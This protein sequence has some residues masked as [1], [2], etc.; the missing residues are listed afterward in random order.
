MVT[1]VTYTKE[2]KD[3]YVTATIDPNDVTS[4][5]D[6]YTYS[7][8]LIAG[9]IDPDA[10]D[11]TQAR[12]VTVTADNGISITE[13]ATADQDAPGADRLPAVEATYTAENTTAWS[14]G[15]IQF[16][17]T[18]DGT[19][20]TDPIAAHNNPAVVTDSIQ[21]PR[22]QPLVI[23]EEFSPSDFS[24]EALVEAVVETYPQSR[25]KSALNRFDTH[26]SKLLPPEEYLPIA[27]ALIE[28]CWPIRKY[29]SDPGMYVAKH[30]FELTSR[31]YFDRDESWYTELL[32]MYNEQ[33]NLPNTDVG[34]VHRAALFRVFT[35]ED[36]SVDDL[37]KVKDGLEGTTWTDGLDD[38][39]FGILCALLYGDGHEERARELAA[40]APIQ[41]FQDEYEEIKQATNEK[42]DAE[43]SA[44]WGELLPTAA[45]I[46]PEEFQFVLGNVA[47]W[48]AGDLTVQ[49]DEYY[50]ASELY[51]VSVGLLNEHGGD[52]Y[53][54]TARARHHY[55]KGV[56]DKEEQRHEKARERF[57]KA[58]HDC[59]V[60]DRPLT[61]AY[62][63]LGAVE[64]L[65]TILLNAARND[66]CV[67]DKALDE[68]HDV[69]EF[70][71]EP[72]ITPYHIEERTEN[73]SVYVTGALAELTARKLERIREEDDGVPTLDQVISQFQKAADSYEDAAH[74]YHTETVT[75]VIEDL[76]DSGSSERIQYPTRDRPD[77]EPSPDE[78]TSQ[79]A[80]SDS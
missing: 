67:I 3:W 28:E 13:H 29:R 11:A 76:T 72:E 38:K 7:V 10:E 24:S 36:S 6:T 17:I 55:T 53:A 54:E 35:D 34:A 75:E 68:L 73:A 51:G 69:A 65:T 16:T 70:L 20:V 2:I 5:G 79:T 62:A 44:L 41:V 26:C 48:T 64:G 22:Y 19:E 33:P 32:E 42:S 23:L 4:D 27:N 12:N 15:S 39:S 78:T 46:S 77:Q 60:D 80:Q 31:V 45:I 74:N 50:R 18:D 30:A 37:E 47:F 52:V 8:T 49:Y 61:D 1:K 57:L 43:Q 58:I 71:P 66:T 63:V 21:I 56:H 40:N 59:Q 9:P 14:G 25:E